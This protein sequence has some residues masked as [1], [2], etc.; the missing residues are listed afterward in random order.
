[1]KL[2]KF[3]I[4]LKLMI[5]ANNL[6]AQTESNFLSDLFQDRTGKL[7]LLQLTLLQ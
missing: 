2:L 7:Y 1:M 6:L 4:C 3:L 5:I